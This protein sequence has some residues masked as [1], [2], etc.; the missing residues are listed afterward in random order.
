MRTMLVVPGMPSGTPA[1]MM[2]RSPARAK[3]SRNAMRQA[4]STMSSWSCASSATMQWTPHT[5]ARRRPVATLGEIAT[6][7]GPGR[8]RATRSAVAPDEV[9]QTT[10]ERSSVSAIWRD[11]AAI[12]SAPVA[13]GSVRW[14]WMIER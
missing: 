5:A 11:A 6:I 14:A 2:T 12:A 1:T 13:S 4:R 7:A 3:P 9:Q 10:A 8:S